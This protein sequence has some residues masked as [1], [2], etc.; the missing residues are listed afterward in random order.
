M[1]NVAWKTVVNLQLAATT[2]HKAKQHSQ[3]GLNSVVD[4]CVQKA[5]MSPKELRGLVCQTK[6]LRA[7]WQL[8]TSRSAQEHADRC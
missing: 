2:F 8:A 7:D 6:G 3:H 4:R 1:G 5:G